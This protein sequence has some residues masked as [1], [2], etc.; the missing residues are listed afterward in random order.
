MHLLVRNTS[1]CKHKNSPTDNPPQFVVSTKYKS[2]RA[3]GVNIR[4]AQ[5]PLSAPNQTL[6][7][8]EIEL[9]NVSL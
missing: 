4:S 5:L 1:A 9:W 3:Y 6:N 7:T 8:E 2:L